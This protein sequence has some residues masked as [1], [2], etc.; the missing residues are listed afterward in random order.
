MHMIATILLTAVML[1]SPNQ[2]AISAELKI[3]AETNSVN[4]PKNEPQE[5]SASTENVYLACGCGCCDTT[6]FTEHCL[7]KNH[8]ES[9]EQIVADDRKI[10][11]NDQVCATVGCSMA[12]RYRYCD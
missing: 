1:L 10:A 2:S 6:R 12:V 8:G 4:T 9:L 11:A 5:Q 7:Y 3:A